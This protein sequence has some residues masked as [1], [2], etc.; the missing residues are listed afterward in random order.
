MSFSS[1]G[2]TVQSLKWDP[3]GERLAVLFEETNIVALFATNVRPD[4]SISPIG[5][6]SGQPNEKPACIEFSKKFDEGALLTIVRNIVCH[7][8]FYY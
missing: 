5:L 6:I 8:I 2:G 4:F 7:K 1:I 3:M